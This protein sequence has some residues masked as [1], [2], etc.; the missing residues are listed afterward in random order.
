VVENTVTLQ[1]DMPLYEKF[2]LGNEMK[3]FNQKLRVTE[4]NTATCTGLEGQLP[5]LVKAGDTHRYAHLEGAKGA[6]ITAEYDEQ[7]SVTFH[8]G[9]WVDPFDIKAL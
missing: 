7:H 2:I 3:L 1:G 6:L 5:E 4:L 8:K 9:L